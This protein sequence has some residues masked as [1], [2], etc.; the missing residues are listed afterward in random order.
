MVFFLFLFLFKF[1]LF[2]LLC[3]QFI[4]CIYVELSCP[5][6]E[7]HC[8]EEEFSWV[9]EMFPGSNRCDQ[10]RFDTSTI[11]GSLWKQK[12]LEGWSW[13]RARGASSFPLSGVNYSTNQLPPP[14]PPP[15]SDGQPPH[16][17][18]S[19]ASPWLF[20][21]FL[22]LTGF[23]RTTVWLPGCSL[24]GVW[25]LL[26]GLLSFE[27][28]GG[29]TDKI[30]QSSL[31]LLVDNSHAWFVLFVIVITLRSGPQESLFVSSP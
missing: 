17:P 14:P 24:G 26:T 30:C 10:Q 6:S 7:G 20:F 18:H 12:S 23:H 13:T 29:R 4:Y 8:R 28:I 2:H 9:T 1:V 21:F 27:L 11:T 19:T 3:V 31:F 25:L 15:S 22:H 16:D 5:T